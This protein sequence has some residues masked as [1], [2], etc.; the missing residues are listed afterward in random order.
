[1]RKLLYCMFFFTLLSCGDNASIGVIERSDEPE[2]PT[3]T[4]ANI[5]AKESYQIASNQETRL[6]ALSSNLFSKV[7]LFPYTLATLTNGQDLSNEFNFDNSILEVKVYDRNVSPKLLIGSSSYT[8]QGEFDEMTIALTD[9]VDELDGDL[10]INKNIQLNDLFEIQY[11]F[12]P[13]I[14]YNGEAIHYPPLSDQ[15]EFRIQETANDT[16]LVNYT[17]DLQ[18]HEDIAC[19]NTLGLTLRGW[20]DS[21]SSGFI[22]LD[23]VTFSLD[24]LV[25]SNFNLL[26]NTPR[27]IRHFDIELYRKSDQILIYKSD[28]SIPLPAP[29]D[30][31]R[32]QPGLFYFPTGALKC[33]DSSE[34]YTIEYKAHID[35]VFKI[36]GFQ[37]AHIKGFI[38]FT[39]TASPKTGECQFNYTDESPYVHTGDTFYFRD[40]LH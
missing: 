13:S 9:I 28:S 27:L 33:I 14:I 34:E 3:Q 31:Y 39:T 37:S 36:E 6:D 29:Y 24:P 38:D 20:G 2:I 8:F 32:N 18:Q 11:T 15:F 1:M 12:T 7:R 17:S 22:R 23:I 30:I 35:A 25:G 16:T 21:S 19:P 10:N 4:L 26:E 5:C 40:G